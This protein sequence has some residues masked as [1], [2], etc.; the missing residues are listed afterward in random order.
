MSVAYPIPG[1]GGG[2]G[3][4]SS[5]K[6]ITNA[7]TGGA[8]GLRLTVGAGGSGTTVEIFY[9]VYLR[10]I[11][12]GPTYNYTYRYW[13]REVVNKGSS[14]KPNWQVKPDSPA[15]LLPVSGTALTTALGQ[16][17]PVSL[18]YESF[19]FPNVTTGKGPIPALFGW[20]GDGQGK[21]IGTPYTDPK[22]NATFQGP[23]PFGWKPDNPITQRPDE[24]N[25]GD[26]VPNRDENTH[27]VTP[28]PPS[29]PV[30]GFGKKRKT[31]WNP[32]PI[33]TITGAYVPVVYDWEGNRVKVD[34]TESK[35]RQSLLGYGSYASRVRKKA[36]IV[37]WID[38]EDE[39]RATAGSA[40]GKDGEVTDTWDDRTAIVPTGVRYGFRFT[41]NPSE[42]VFQ[43]NPIV[44]LDPGVIISGLGKSYPMGD[45]D[46]GSIQV[47]T[48]LNRIEDMAFIRSSGNGF[49][50]TSGV[51]PYGD[52]QL[53]QAQMKGIATRGTGFDLEYLFR[54]SLG[55]PFPTKTRGITADI[56]LI[57]G[58][59]L[60]VNFGGRM[61]Y[62][63]RLT[64]LSYSHMYFTSEMVPTFT[65]VSM[66][67]SRFPDATRFNA[68]PNPGGPG[69]NNKPKKKKKK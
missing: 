10:K 9:D 53:T 8:A 5:G 66:S 15:R 56:G 1:E 22:G 64:S 50:L 6:R 19:R 13:Y 49:A 21:K 59:P 18:L 69:N 68:T 7:M 39:W 47:T 34:E 63:G 41:Y 46:G 29:G 27:G 45:E 31:Q 25:D 32:P 30:R 57:L 28:P 44:G 42:I 4:I 67:F 2:P 36:T 37:Q 61:S 23:N 55:K 24:D 43:M 65:Q 26:G 60:L 16:R 3:W 54:T 51:S 62:T 38:I 11:G 33:R 12:A 17:L 35:T 14:T 48:Y 52:R 58:L 40:T 20:K